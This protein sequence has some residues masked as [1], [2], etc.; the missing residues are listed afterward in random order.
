MATVAKGR[1]RSSR[2]NLYEIFLDNGAPNSGGALLDIKF[3]SGRTDW[4][5]DSDDIDGHILASKASV[6]FAVTSNAQKAIFDGLVEANELQYRLRIHKDG[7][8]DWVGFVLLDIVSYDFSG[9]PYFFKVAATDG[10]SRLKDVDYEQG[11]LSDF[12]TVSE[13]LL[14]ILSYVPL[15]DYYASGDRYLSTHVTRWPDGLTPSASLNQLTRL[16]TNFKALRTV[17]KKGEITLSSAYDA[18]L[19]ILKMLGSR[20]VY[21][22]GRYVLSETLDYSRQSAAV[23]FHHFDIGGSSLSADSL[24]SWAPQTV[25]IGANLTDAPS[26]AFQGGKVTLLPPLKGVD[27][28]YKH[29]SRQNLLP[30]Y[31][32]TESFQPNAELEGFRSNGGAG[33]LLLTGYL[34]FLIVPSGAPRV[35]SGAIF[36]VF[37]VSIAIKNASGVVIKSLKRGAIITPSG[38]SYTEAEWS[39]GSHSYEIAIPA[40]PPQ[41]QRPQDGNFSL[42]SPVINEEGTLSLDFSTVR[43]VDGLNNSITDVAI[44]YTV[45]DVFLESLLAGSISDQYD[46]RNFNPRTSA[47]SDNSVVLEREMIFGDGPDENTFGRIIFSPS[48]NVW[49][50]T[51]GWR[52]WENGAYLNATSM[53]IGGLSAQSILA[54]QAT[55]KEVLNIS[56]AAPDYAAH[57][58]FGCDGDVFIMQSATRQMDSDSWRGRWFEVGSNFIDTD[59]PV[60]DTNV[61]PTGDTGEGSGGAPDVPTT[62]TGGTPG[63]SGGGV[64]PGLTAPGIN[65]I[66]S[67]TDDGVAADVEIGGLT[68]PDLTDTPLFAGDIV[69]IINPITGET[70]VVEV[71]HDSGFIPGS[72][73]DN[74][75]VPYY[76]ADGLEWLVPSTTEVAIVAVTPTVDF[77]TGSYLQPDPQATAQLQGLLRTDH[78]DADLFGYDTNITTGFHPWFWRAG[79]RIGWH[80]KAVHFA[81]AQDLGG[82]AKINLKYYDASG[83]RYT[84]ATHDAGGLGSIQVANA[85]VLAGYMRVQV[86]TI[87]GTAPKGLSV[88]IEMIKINS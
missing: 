42:I 88:I 23:V 84:I 81:F 45:S 76:G 39:T 30:G 28:A 7:V 54:L 78:K 25:Q 72:Q 15:S 86:E 40:P 63:P 69:T 4:K 35:V 51:D 34:E 74:G 3:G 5:L 18:L 27:L 31:V 32:W 68:V 6:E 41:A 8:L 53:P 29:Y 10:L 13:H 60:V 22:E 71:S 16:A 9:Y 49:E 20:L 80:I 79:K 26:V 65:T 1:I 59:P 17:D 82:S 67:A 37:G 64:T 50:L 2:G 58:I 83:F 85:D 36:L 24:S 55:R 12:I 14:H 52:R 75:A 77:P 11:D 19:E 38:A 87:T 62:G 48:T 61:P 33:R 66:L 73:S 44:S 21:S 70:Q 43:Y 46:Y 47:T 57:F 56:V